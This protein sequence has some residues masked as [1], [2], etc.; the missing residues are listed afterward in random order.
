MAIFFLLINS[1]ALVHLLEIVL[2]LD[3]SRVAPYTYGNHES[4]VNNVAIFRWFA[5]F[6]LFLATLFVNVSFQDE[7]CPI[8]LAYSGMFLHCFYMLQH[9]CNYRHL[10]AVVD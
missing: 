10:Y 7:S 8:V 6:P 3:I 4:L 5:L 9:L 2:H 1:N